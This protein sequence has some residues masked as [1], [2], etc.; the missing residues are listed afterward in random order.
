MIMTVNNNGKAIASMVLGIFGIFSFPIISS[1]IALVLGVQARREIAASGGWQ[2]GES[3]AKAGIILGW[4]GIAI[5]SLLFLILIIVA[6]SDP[7]AFS[8]PLQ[9]ALLIHML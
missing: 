2:T 7:D 8:M 9:I 4:V 6:V 1:I 3:M 5:Y